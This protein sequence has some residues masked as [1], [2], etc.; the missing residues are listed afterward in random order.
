ME[1]KEEPFKPV[2]RLCFQGSI[3]FEDPVEAEIWY[4]M[5]KEMVKH[6]SNISTLNGTIIKGL[7]P[8]CGK[9]PIQKFLAGVPNVSP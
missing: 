5:L 9:N 4:N 1:N 2:M 8:C 6:K 3:P 7:E